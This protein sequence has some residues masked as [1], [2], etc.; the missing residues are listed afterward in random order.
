VYDILADIFAFERNPELEDCAGVLHRVAAWLRGLL[1]RALIAAPDAGATYAD[2]ANDML[3]LTLE[4]GKPAAYA[5]FIRNQF[6]RRDVIE[7]PGEA[8]ASQPPAGPLAPKVCDKPGARQ[9]RRA[10]CGTMNLAEYHR[11]DRVLDSEAQAL[12]RWCAANGRLGECVL[13]TAA[14]VPVA[15]EQT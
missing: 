12:A 11:V 4:D 14:V 10:C 5:G 7:Q 13:P 1:L 6:A 8:A 3:R 2:V 9:D 15:A